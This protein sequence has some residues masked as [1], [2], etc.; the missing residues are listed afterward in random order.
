LCGDSWKLKMD[1]FLEKPI[2]YK[3]KFFEV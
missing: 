1:I 2:K 3:K